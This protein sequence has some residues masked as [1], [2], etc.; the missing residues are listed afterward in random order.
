M[1]L[2]RYD[3]LIAN[4][5]YSDDSGSKSRP[6]MVVRFDNEVGSIISIVVFTHYRYYR[7]RNLYSLSLE[8][9]KTLHCS[10]KEWALL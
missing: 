1:D 7:A 10:S 3:L 9:Y 5:K 6:A 4:V 2:E 8:F